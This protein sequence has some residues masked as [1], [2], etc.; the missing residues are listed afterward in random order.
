M[1]KP[2]DEVIREFNELVNMS[3]SE[4]E[5][6]LK[7]SLAARRLGGGG[8]GG[9]DDCSQLPTHPRPTSQRAAGGATAGRVWVTT[10]E[11]LQA[12]DGQVWHR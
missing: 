6:W 9:D 1:V 5:E 7:V 2:D 8:G 12:C 4:L 3:A 11:A 10:G